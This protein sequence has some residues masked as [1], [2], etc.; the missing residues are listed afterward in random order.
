MCRCRLR[1]STSLVIE[2]CTLKL[3]VQHGLDI[4]GTDTPCSVCNRLLTTLEAVS[5]ARPSG[6]YRVNGLPY[7]G[8]DCAAWQKTLFHSGRLLPVAVQKHWRLL[9]KLAKKAKRLDLCHRRRARLAKA[10]VV[11]GG[12]VSDRRPWPQCRLPQLSKATTAPG[13]AW[14]RVQGHDGQ[15]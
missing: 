4:L 15:Q 5:P 2:Q 13:P 10:C 8:W 9:L 14:E 7:V 3:R 12:F 1:S 6:S 11:C